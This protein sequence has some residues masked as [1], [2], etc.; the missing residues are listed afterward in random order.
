[1]AEVRPVSITGLSILSALGRGGEA[2]LAAALSGSA[3]FGPVRRFDAAGRRVRTAATAADVAPL[4]DELAS[5][6]GT[7]CAEAGW[8]GADKAAAPLFLAAHGHPGLSGDARQLATRTGVAAPNRIYTSACVSASTAIA[9]A[10]SLIKR[11]EYD[12]I[13]VAAGY[14]V[15]PGQYALFDAG[16]ALSTDDVVRPFSLGRQGLLLGDAVV[17]MTLQAGDGLAEVAGWGR[18]GDAFHPCQPDPEGKGLARAITAALGR[19]AVAPDQVGYINANA[20]GT[21]FSDAAE[22]AALQRVFGQD[23]PPVSST[24]AVHGH[25]LEASGLLEL[26]ITVLALNAGK[27]PVNAGYLGPD[28]A[29][30]LDLVLDG[31]RRPGTSYGLSLNSAF[32]GA[33]TALLVRAA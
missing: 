12:R 9:D 23:T 16:R 5:A 22:A 30:P 26:A 27:L 32:G 13:V 21:K 10:A 15:E 6:I 18:A 29:C 24:K 3:A 8:T 1:M 17:A 28:P 20:T 2:Q 25:A 31:P 4:Q 33:N 11:G 14:L 19:A 7:A